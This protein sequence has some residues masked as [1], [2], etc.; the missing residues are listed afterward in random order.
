ISPPRYCALKGNDQNNCLFKFVDCPLILLIGQYLGEQRAAI[1]VC[2][3]LAWTGLP[4]PATFRPKIR[5]AIALYRGAY[6]AV[7]DVQ[8]KI[9]DLHK[10]LGF[11]PPP[12]PPL[13]PSP[14]DIEK[15]FGPIVTKLEKAREDAEALVR[16]PDIGGFATAYAGAAAAV[17][18]NALAAGKKLEN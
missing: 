11:A 8:S 2:G 10:K 18:A 1:S 3:P 15:T 5:D 6:Q 17:E 14:E 4:D 12:F 13:P 16:I 7:H 9:L